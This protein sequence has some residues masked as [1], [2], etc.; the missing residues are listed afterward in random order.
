MATAV[1]ACGLSMA[2]AQESS[3]QQESSR[4]DV[5]AEETTGSSVAEAADIRLEKAPPMTPEALFEQVIERARQ[6]AG[7][8]YQAP[9]SPLPDSLANMSYNDYRDIRF[10]QESALWRDER[11]FEV[12]FFHPGF[13]YDAPV[14]T[15]VL[16][17]GRVETLDFD[18]SM[19]NY[20]K[21]AAPL[22][23]EVARLDRQK[24]GFAGFRLHYPLNTPHYK[25]E[26]LVFLG[27]SYFRIAG[28]GQGYG[29]SAR[30][31]AVNTATQ[32]GEEF[33]AFRAFWLVQPDPEASTITLFAL[34]DSPS[35]TG[36]YRFDVEAANNTVIDVDAH[37][38]ARS[39]VAKLGV[40][41]LTSMF[42]HGENSVD[43]H[44]DF[45]PEV[46]D[47]DGML[48]HT[49]GGQW[50]WRPLSN[51]ETLNVTQLRDTSPR[52]FGLMQRDRDFDSYLDMEADYQH[53]PSL[54]IEPREGDWNEG[55]LELVE[56]PVE[57]EV[58]DNIVAYWVPDSAFRAG[59]ARRYQYRV[60][61]HGDGVPEHRLGRVVR[62]RQGWGAVPGE[63][64]PPEHSLRRFIVDFRGGEALSSLAGSQPVEAKLTVARGE[65][66]EL[67][68]KQL[69]DGETWRATF[70]LAP[71]G[72]ESADMQ[73]QL[74]LRGRLLTETWSYIWNPN[75][76]E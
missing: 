16:K 49:S 29:I 48:M 30:G 71:K 56:I 9:S 69:P 3:G 47:S 12:Q 54:W 14:E 60:T 32:G 34:L 39:E 41:P 75:V 64:D 7:G 70:K 24:L 66:S 55:G 57:S 42:L 20:E 46:H 25:D 26:F 44:D 28:R 53:R 72:E 58:H 38:F 74:M 10:R 33:P 76:L 37:L 21:D 2:Q 19:F 50:I 65:I 36:A 59:D 31:L 1:L 11:L 51:P 43:R 18:M 52:G 8:E 68:V 45:R 23:E 40:A 73:L 27:A 35:V 22:R 67:R 15:H 13:L 6:M 5:T 62:T 63:P 4:S 61:S 17:E